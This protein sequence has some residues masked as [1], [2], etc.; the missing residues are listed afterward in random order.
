MGTL[1]EFRTLAKGAI[2]HVVLEDCLK[3][4]YK[5]Y[6]EQDDYPDCQI[7]SFVCDRA[8]KYGI[9]NHNN[10]QWFFNHGS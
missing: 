3:I 7:I 8:E 5:I 1:K 4:K 9:E 2:F 10:A 6:W